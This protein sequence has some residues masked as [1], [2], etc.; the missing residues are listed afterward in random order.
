MTCIASFCSLS[1]LTPSLS[2][3]HKRIRLTRSNK[4]LIML[5]YN[6]LR[7]DNPTPLPHSK[8]ASAFI[9]LSLAWHCV[10]KWFTS[11]SSLSAVHVYPI[12]TVHPSNCS[13]L[14]SIA[15][16]SIRSCLVLFSL[17][18]DPFY[19]LV[20]QCCYGVFIPLIVLF[21]HHV[22]LSAL[23]I[24]IQHARTDGSFCIV[25]TFYFYL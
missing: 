15:L 10:V 19:V 4:D 1:N 16:Q 6:I 11:A 12:F 23:K 17:L 20:L 25:A 14:L 18:Q 7:I 2:S 13:F 9:G 21:G 5:R 24:R 8:P 22:Y 3:N